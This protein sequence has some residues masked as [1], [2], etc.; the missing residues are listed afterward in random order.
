[1]LINL[2]YNELMNKVFIYST[3]WCAYCKMA[4]EYFKK[5]NVEYTEYDV[6]SDAVKRQEM[7]DKTH[8]MGVPVI[9]INDKIVIGFDRGK[10]NQL[11]EI[12]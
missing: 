1:M 11:L 8:Q 3:P 4:K 9:I 2:C 7:L 10:I 12:K 5:N 6:A